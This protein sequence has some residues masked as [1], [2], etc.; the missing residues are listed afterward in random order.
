M[1]TTLQPAVRLAS[2]A[3]DPDSVTG[4]MADGNLPD[5]PAGDVLPERRRRCRQG[6]Q[7]LRRCAR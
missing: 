5:V 4:W 6:A 2:L 1:H 7:D 3:H